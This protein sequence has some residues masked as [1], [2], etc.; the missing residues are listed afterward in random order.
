M[1]SSPSKGLRSPDVT[2]KLIVIKFVDDEGENKEEIDTVKSG[3][4]ALVSH[5]DIRNNNKDIL[6]VAYQRYS[7]VISQ[8]LAAKRHYRNPLFGVLATAREQ[9]VDFITHALF[10]D[11]KGVVRE[12]DKEWKVRQA[13]CD[14]VVKSG[15]D[16]FN[17]YN[18]VIVSLEMKRSRDSAPSPVSS[19]FDQWT[20]ERSAELAVYVDRLANVFGAPC[21]GITALRAAAMSR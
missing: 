3:L 20:Q 18:D 8:F 10:C 19:L 1:I 7:Q 13:Y 11:D 2:G 17:H 6:Q 14:A 9:M 21:R 4:L 12:A 5:R 16:T 15:F